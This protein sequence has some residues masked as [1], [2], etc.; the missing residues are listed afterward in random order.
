MSLLVWRWPIRE[1]LLAFV[2]RARE[3]ARQEYR[4]EVLVWAVTAPHMRKKT[5]PPDVP[6]ILRAD[7]DS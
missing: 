5:K 4:S 6:A 7:G 3:T 1:A 2:E